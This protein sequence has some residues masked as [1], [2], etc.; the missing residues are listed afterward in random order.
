MSD[1]LGGLD[2]AQLHP[3]AGLGQG[4]EYLEL[5]PSVVGYTPNKSQKTFL[6]SRGWSDDL[7]YG[8]GGTYL[9]GLSIGGAWG[10]MEGMRRARQ[11][12]TSSITPMA[13]AQNVAAMEGVA[14]AGAAAA[15]ATSSSPRTRVSA[16]LRLNTVL[17]AMTR[18]GPFIGNS[19]GVVALMYNVIHSTIGGLRN[20]K[21][22]LASSLASG[23][24]AAALFKSTTGLR[25]MGTAAL[26]GLGAASAWNGAKYVILGSDDS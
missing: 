2:A 9:T 26:M 14:G 5:D 17:N 4:L 7:C 12:A 25:P 8:T 20:G 11:L 1:L 23:T 18:R 6:P 24:I 13:A 10:F 19:C 15:P 16:R 3:M 21:Q 22:D